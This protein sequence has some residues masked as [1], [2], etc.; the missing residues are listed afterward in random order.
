LRIWPKEILFFKYKTHIIKMRFNNYYDYP[1]AKLILLITKELMILNLIIVS[2]SHTA[3]YD[4]Y[5]NKGV[6]S[7]ALKL[8]RINVLVDIHLYSQDNHRHSNA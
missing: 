7:L 2:Y 1:Y 6:T 3:I 5:D 8:F 4:V